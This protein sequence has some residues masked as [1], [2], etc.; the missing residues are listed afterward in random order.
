MN[1]FRTRFGVWMEEV[2]KYS[3]YVANGGLLFTLYFTLIYGAFVYNQFLNG[4][5][6]SFPS[7][8][9]VALAFLVL[10]L[11]HR[12]RT[13]IREADQ[14]F[15]LPE[16]G[17]I[18]S[19]MNG[20][21]LFNVVFASIRALVLM[22][23]LLPLLVRTLELTSAEVFALV[24][25]SILL[26]VVGRLAKL[27]GIRFV[28]VASAVA[29]GGLMFLGMPLLTP[30]P[31]LAALV[32]L[33]IR[34]YERIPL[35]EWLALEQTSKAQFNRIVSWFVDLPEMREEVKERKLVV[36]MI[37]RSVLARA[38]AARY[39]YGL[40]I[41][42]SKDSLDLIIR[43]SLVAVLVMWLAGGWY[44]GIVVPLFVGLTALQLV[45]L[46]KRLDTVSIASWLPI[47]R[48]ER[49]TAYKWWTLRLLVGQALGL[50]V[51]SL[52]FGASWDAL[53]GLLVAYGIVRYY[54]SRL[55]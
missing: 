5:D 49:L 10:P 8:W 9:V 12:P 17:S 16:L 14:V 19:Y 20:V 7:E 34:R 22:L 35:L 11:G 39:M 6:T 29:S 38:D 43:L 54:L 24:F 50:C 3:R 4:L 53:V 40:R 46:F 37:E 45:P 26:S 25:A 2:V 36:K 28:G 42:R 44:V 15:L 18:R 33:H 52:F 55:T 23:V 32:F 47:T 27:E 30:L 1:V 31:A 13:L 48:L 41:A 51:V 21:R